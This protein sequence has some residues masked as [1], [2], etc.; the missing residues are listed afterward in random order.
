V[1]IPDPARRNQIRPVNSGEVKSPIRPADYVPPTRTFRET[2]PGH[3][4]QEWDGDWT[5]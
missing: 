1:P 2:S 4:V 5:P 3:I